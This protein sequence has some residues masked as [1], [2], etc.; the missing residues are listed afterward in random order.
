DCPALPREPN[1]AQRPKTRRSRTPENDCNESQKIPPPEWVRTVKDSRGKLFGSTPR[2]FVFAPNRAVRLRLIQLL[3]D[4]HALSPPCDGKITVGRIDVPDRYRPR[5]RIKPKLAD[6]S[7]SNDRIT[8]SVTRP[9]ARDTVRTSTPRPKA[10]I[11]ITV[12]TVATVPIGAISGAGRM[13]AERS[14]TM[15]RKPTMNHGTS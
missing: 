1:R 2:T 5:K 8:V 7:I 10:A 4:R 13:L 3:Q 12:K 6:P 15:T 11:E 9:P 14:T